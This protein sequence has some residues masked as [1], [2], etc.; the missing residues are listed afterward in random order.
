[1]SRPKYWD[2]T[3]VGCGEVIDLTVFPGSPGNRQGQR[4]EWEEPQPPSFDP[5]ECGDC[6][7]EIKPDDLPI[8][9]ILGE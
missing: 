4:D 8:D 2:H 7:R 9:E 1:M 5:T 3:C 6:G